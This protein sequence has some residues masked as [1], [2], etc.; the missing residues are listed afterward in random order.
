MPSDFERNMLF[1]EE[2][3][4]FID[5]LESDTDPCVNLD[6]GIAA[7]Q[8]VLAAKASASQRREAPFR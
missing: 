1:V 5:C 6:D 4:H 7:L 3:K 8:L 2:A